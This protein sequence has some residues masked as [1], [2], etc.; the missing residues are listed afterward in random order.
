METID[1]TTQNTAPVEPEK[2]TTWGIRL[3]ESE[4][5]KLNDLLEII[6][7]DKKETLLDVLSKA[8]VEH[9]SQQ[10]T[11]GIIAE[12]E[13]YTKAIMQAALRQATAAA[14]VETA[15]KAKYEELLD[16]EQDA[17]LKLSEQ[18]EALKTQIAGLEQTIKA[19]KDQI[20]KAADRV[21]EQKE[22][23]YCLK[24]DLETAQKNAAAVA[25][26]QK[27]YGNRLKAAE[28]AKTAAEKAAA[29]ALAAQQAAEKATADAN[30]KVANI[31]SKYNALN[32]KLEEVQKQL[33]KAEARA[34]KAEERLDKANT[35]KTELADK[36][37]AI[38]M[39]S[40][41]TS[42]RKAAVKP[43]KHTD[44]NA[45]ADFEEIL[46]NKGQQKLVQD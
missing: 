4:K 46:E 40:Q 38:A 3:R 5:I 8:A 26:I 35:E 41:H 39:Q 19:Q 45:D 12:M 27:E 17:K 24:N 37:A 22:E 18:I 44:A 20:S 1:N 36:L 13:T 29:D 16:I 31:A 28:A 32:G 2:T 15:T 7:G 30:G 43:A 6:G 11:T 14:A 23:I 10:A 9:Q 42:S 25:E 21:E 34:D 33:T